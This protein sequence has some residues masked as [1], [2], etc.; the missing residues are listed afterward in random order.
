M[1][2]LVQHG[3]RS[4]NMSLGLRERWQ[5]FNL[6]ELLRVERALYRFELYCIFF[7]DPSFRVVEKGVGQREA[8]WNYFAPWEIEQIAS[9]S[10]Y[11]QVAVLPCKSPQPSSTRNRMLTCLSRRTSRNDGAKMDK[12]ATLLQRLQPASR[13][14]YACTDVAG[15]TVCAFIHRSRSHTTA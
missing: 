6:Q 8:F 9:V 15:T 10:E 12:L 13:R 7:G 4:A 5:S 11:I 3:V 14:L 2:G 1:A